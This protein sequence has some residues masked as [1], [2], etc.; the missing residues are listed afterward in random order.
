MTI[1]NLGVY[2]RGGIEARSFD[3][4][5][6]CEA[7]GELTNVTPSLVSKTLGEILDVITSTARPEW[8]IKSLTNQIDS[9]SAYWIDPSLAWA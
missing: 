7:S 3:R 4:S 9:A 2:N 6:A 8:V 1:H 5:W